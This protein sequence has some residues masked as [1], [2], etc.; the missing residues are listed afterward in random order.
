[1][2]LR[3]EP[4]QAR[5][6]STIGSL[7]AA[8]R[9]VINRS[10]RDRFTTAEIAEEAGVSIGTLYRY[11]SDRSD[12]LDRIWPDRDAHLPEGFVL[13]PPSETSEYMVHEGPAD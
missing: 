4:K 2:D 9:T 5:S 6:K 11:F 12:V 13:E 10:G 7:E 8:A 1:M 3:H